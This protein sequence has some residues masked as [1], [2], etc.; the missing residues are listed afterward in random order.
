MSNIE[1]PQSLGDVVIFNTEDGA[2]NVQLDLVDETVWVNQSGIAELFSTSKQVVSYHLGNI[3]KEGEL[4]QNSVVKEILTTAEDNKRYK[5]KFYNLDAVI[6]VGY[7]INSKRATAFRIWATKVLR[8]YLIKGFALDDNRFKKG[9]SLTHFKEL[10]DRIREIRLS[11]KVF[12]QQIKDIYKLSED[13]DPNDENTVMFFKRVQNKLLWAVSGKTAAELIYYRANSDLPQMGLT[14]TEVDGIVKSTDVGIGKNYL[15]KEEIEALKLIVEQY[16]SFA[17]A[18]AQAH[19]PMYM[20]DWMENLDLI[21]QMNRRDIL[22][23][24]GRISAELAK[25]KV[26]QVFS[27]YKEKQRHLE[28][29]ESLKELEREKIESLKELERD[30]SEY[31]RSSD[32]I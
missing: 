14:S 27:E 17:E 13:Y 5:V 32:C 28:K 20:K 8:D 16:L 3:F 18:Q 10:I 11:E 21:L 7:R 23:G 1:K 25:K 15:S 2:V 26:R 29:I 4:V 22:D 30:L 6:A 24:P 9:Q 19:R 31:R 12:Y